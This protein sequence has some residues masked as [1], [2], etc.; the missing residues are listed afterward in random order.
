MRIGLAGLALGGMA[1]SG[2]PVA[3]QSKPASAAETDP[4]AEMAI[5]SGW[6]R[7]PQQPMPI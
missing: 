4:A 1:L 3:A 7:I 6:H 2:A 5:V